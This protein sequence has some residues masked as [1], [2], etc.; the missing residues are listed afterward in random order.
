LITG[1]FNLQTLG[2]QLGSDPDFLRFSEIESMTAGDDLDESG[3]T[4]LKVAPR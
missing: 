1:Q 3:L 4:S 2:N